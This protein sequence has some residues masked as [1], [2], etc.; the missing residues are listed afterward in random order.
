MLMPSRIAGTMADHLYKSLLG[1]HQPVG[2]SFS[3]ILIEIY[4]HS[5]IAIIPILSFIFSPSLCFCIEHSVLF[6]PF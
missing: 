1:P 5:T 6:A 2:S 3:F 4:S